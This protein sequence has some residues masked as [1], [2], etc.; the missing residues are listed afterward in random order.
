MYAVQDTLAMFGL[1]HT[2]MA[3]ANQENSTCDS[4]REFTKLYV[5]HNLRCSCEY[6]AI[7]QSRN[8][9]QHAANIYLQFSL[10]LSKLPRLGSII[11]GHTGSRIASV[12]D[13]TTW[14]THV[15]CVGCVA[16]P[17]R[18]AGTAAASPHHSCSICE[19]FSKSSYIGCCRVCRCVYDRTE[20][21][22]YQAMAYHMHACCSFCAY[23][24]LCM[25]QAMESASQP[26]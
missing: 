10:V 5:S 7:H 17:I 4:K 25:H 11:P 14:K 2:A 20:H 9:N 6:A 26:S 21:M 16:V 3:L 22:L 24:K 19:Q 13:A 23:L 8:F 15:C 12:A 18:R 1:C